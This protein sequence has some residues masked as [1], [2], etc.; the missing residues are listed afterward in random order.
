[1]TQR[2][3]FFDYITDLEKECLTKFDNLASK[4][5]SPKISAVLYTF[6]SRRHLYLAATITM[7]TWDS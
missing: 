1:M 3:G 6:P 5:I 4:L 7:T 2:F